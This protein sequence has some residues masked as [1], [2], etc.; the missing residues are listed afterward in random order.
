[1]VGG[2]IHLGVSNRCFATKVIAMWL[3]I[4]ED[5]RLELVANYLHFSGF[6]DIE[7]VNLVTSGMVGRLEGDW[8]VN[9]PLWVVRGKK[10]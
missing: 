4:G 8:G 3:R 9:D 1:M 6:E 7:V 2:S 10:M 5:Q